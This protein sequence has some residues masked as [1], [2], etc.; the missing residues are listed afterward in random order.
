MSFFIRKDE[1]GNV[2]KDAIPIKRDN[3]CGFYQVVVDTW[4]PKS[5]IWAL[6]FGP[7][8]LGVAGALS[9]VYGSMYFRRKLRLRHYGI[10]STYLPNAV[11]PFLLVQSFH[12]M[13]SH[14]LV[15]FTFSMI[16]NFI[17]LL[18]V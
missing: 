5:E 2:P 9:G 1:E 16:D 18:L 4:K 8:I 6:T 11:L 13:V 14:Y 10:F 17:V 3:V 7:S 15:Y 12:Q